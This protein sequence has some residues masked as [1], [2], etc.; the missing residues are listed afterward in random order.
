MFI[1]YTVLLF[2]MSTARKD[3]TM[4]TINNKRANLDIRRAVEDAGFYLWQVAEEIG[5]T[6]GTFSRK[7]RTEMTSEQKATVFHALDQ[8][9]KRRAESLGVQ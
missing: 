3:F 8:L 5:C 7:M 9:K 6:D 1:Y 4:T 2:T